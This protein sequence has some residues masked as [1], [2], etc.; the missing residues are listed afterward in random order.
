MDVSVTVAPADSRQRTAVD[1]ASFTSA[2]ESGQSIASFIT[3]TRNPEIESFNALLYSSVG[4][5][6]RTHC[7][8]FGS[9]P[10]IAS[11]AKA[12]SSTEA[13]IGQTKSIV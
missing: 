3:P 11:R 7:G 1:T 9:F 8:S 13:A 6:P 4:M 5:E 12:T 10:A 2:S